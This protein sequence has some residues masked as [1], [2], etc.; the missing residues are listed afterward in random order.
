MHQD[1]TKLRKYI[2]I[3]P[4][5]KSSYAKIGSAQLTEHEACLKNKAFRMN[6]VD[7]EYILEEDWK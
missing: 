4:R 5:L 3:N 1:T 2:L 7:K 6:K